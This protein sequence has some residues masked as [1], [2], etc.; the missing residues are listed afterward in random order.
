[1]AAIDE[2][3]AALEQT[4]PDFRGRRGDWAGVL[5]RAQAREQD[6]QGR[7]GALLGSRRRRIGVLVVAVV[8]VVGTASAFA[9]VRSLVAEPF[10]HEHGKMS[11]TVDGVRFSFFV[12]GG[13]VVENGLRDVG[14]ENG[15]IERDG[16]GGFREGS[17]YISR[18]MVYGQGAEA[19]IFWTGFPDRGE[20]P[21]CTK[22]LSPSVGRSPGALAAA[23]ARAPGT[24][25][26]KRP[27]RVT[28]GGRPA[29]Q[30]VLSVRKDLGCDP[31]FFFTWRHGECWGACWLETSVGDTIRVW[32]V[33]VDGKRLVIA[34]ATKDALMASWGTPIGRFRTYHPRK[35][36]AQEIA[37]IV[38]SIRFD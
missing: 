11:R 22:L 20:A 13:R 8:V 5:A 7:F 29:T 1:M 15:P 23:M 16:Q 21:P 33:D 14:W 34:A 9:G 30:V 36:V 32:I 35:E 19:V 2:I 28:V 31:G 12:P 26:V 3:R 24:K 17:L 37:G 4:V 25:L 27:T 6:R 10:V 38:R 18:S